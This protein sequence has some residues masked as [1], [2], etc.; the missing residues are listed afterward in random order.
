[1]ESGEGIERL[2]FDLASESRLG[3]LRELKDKNLKMN[4]LGRKLDLTATEAFRQL[5]RLSEAKLIQKLPEGTYELTQIGKLTLQ[6][7][8]SLEFIFKH[9]EYFLNHDIWR[10]P[11]SF[12][13]RIG[14]LSKGTLSMD[15][16]ENMNKA[17]HIVNEAEKYVWGIGDK[18]LESI[19]PAMAEGIA[20]GVKFRFM[21][22]ESLL[23]KYKP[24]SGEAQ[25]MEKRTLTEIPGMIFCTEKE[26]GICLPL[27]EG[28]MD[29][30]GFFSKDQMFVNWTGDLFQYYWDR[31]KRCF[32]E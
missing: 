6:L 10:L 18:A 20:K 23:S 24:V 13:N 9:K 21:F 25:F 32:P 2:L 15:T 16:I 3:I 17:A 12:V 28:R 1:M 5:Q 7:L 19:G 31:G 22:H 8:P 11:Y 4:E 30:A 29:Y 26:A 27:T 14:E